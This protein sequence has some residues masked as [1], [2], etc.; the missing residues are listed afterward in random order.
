MPFLLD[1]TCQSGHHVTQAPNL[2]N[3][4][5]LNSDVAH[6]QPLGDGAC[7]QAHILT[8]STCTCTAGQ[9]TN[10]CCTCWASDL[11]QSALGAD[12]S[13]PTTQAVLN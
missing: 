2:G 9:H 11:L 10:K 1:C 6:M 3:W 4:S 12:E 7:T 8:L 5:S 13:A